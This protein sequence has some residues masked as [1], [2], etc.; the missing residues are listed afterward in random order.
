MNGYSGGLGD[1]GVWHDCDSQDQIDLRDCSVP[2]SYVFD[3]NAPSDLAEPH[4]VM[5]G[6][7][8]DK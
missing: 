6:A 1:T 3:G 2:N 5:Y 7:D 8:Q 4:C